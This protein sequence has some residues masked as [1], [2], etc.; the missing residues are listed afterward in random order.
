[1]NRFLLLLALALTATTLQAKQVKVDKAKSIALQFMQTSTMAKSNATNKSVGT[2]LNLVYTATVDDAIA[3][4]AAATTSNLFYVFNQADNGGFVI[5]AADDAVSPILAYS[6]E[7]SF[8]ADNIPCNVKA[9][10]DTYR[11]A[12][13][14]AIE[15]GVD[16]SA[17]WN[18]V[19]TRASE[20][21]EGSYL[22]TS[23]WGQGYPYNAKTPVIAE[24]HCVTG[25]VATAMA[26]IMYYWKYPKAGTGSHEY[27]WNGGG[28]MLSADFTEP[29]D[30]ANMRDTY[31]YN[32]AYTQDEVDAISHLLSQCGISVDMDYYDQSGA[33]TTTMRNSLC[34]YFGYSSAQACSYSLTN[35]GQTEWI[36]IIKEEIDNGRPI[37]YS[38]NGHAYICDGYNS[39]DYLHVNFGWSGGSDGFYQFMGTNAYLNRTY[40]NMECGLIPSDKS[41]Y[42]DD[43]VNTYS[44]KCS[45]DESTVASGT[46]LTFYVNLKHSETVSID[47]VTVVKVDGNNNILEDMGITNYTSISDQSYYASCSVSN[48]Y[49]DQED[50]AEYT[51][52]P[53]YKVDGKWIVATD[54]TPIVKNVKQMSSCS[55]TNM[56]ISFYSNRKTMLVGDVNRQYVIIKPSGDNF[57]GTI[58]VTVNNE[59][60][61]TVYKQTS[62]VVLLSG[63]WTPLPVDY[64]FMEAGT[65]TFNVVAYNSAG[66]KIKTAALELTVYEETYLTYFGYDTSKYDKVAELYPNAMVFSPNT[67]VHLKASFHNPTSQ[68]VTKTYAIS[69][70]AKYYNDVTASS[71][72]AEKTITIPANGDASAYIDVVV[73]SDDT[74]SYNYFVL[75]EKSDDSSYS[76]PSTDKTATST[77]KNYIRYTVGTPQMIFSKA[78]TVSGEDALTLHVN[79]EAWMTFYLQVQDA[80]LSQTAGY[81]LIARLYDGDKQVGEYKGTLDGISDYQFSWPIGGFNVSPGTYTLKFALDQMGTEYEI[82]DTSGSVAAYSVKIKNP[83]LLPEQTRILNGSEDYRFSKNN[84]TLQKGE[85]T[86]LKFALTN[87]HSTKFVGTIKVAE[88]SQVTPCLES[89]EKQ[90]TI[91]GNGSENVYGELSVTVPTNYRY[92]GITY[93][94]FAKSQY[95]DEYRAISNA[96]FYATISNASGIDNTT[97]GNGASYTDGVITTDGNIDDARVFDTAGRNV[98]GYTVKGNTLDLRTLPK[99]VYVVKIDTEN[100]APIKVKVVR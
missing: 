53:A 32:T 96:S 23:K 51:F 33:S 46:Q 79:T 9:V 56:Y 49:N 65:Y 86:K 35:V 30:W 57:K 25:C 13:T 29:F 31:D 24:E 55:A 61:K 7:N 10:L 83:D 92:S 66:T 6:H 75:A 97:I 80:G 72:L 99:G 27:Y 37:V 52:M 82:K 91:D 5:V 87:P 15:S 85:T 98:A 45:S 18:N 67:T 78:P 81:S 58:E 11:D 36:R 48:L 54:A 59:A 90:I 70:Q 68:S 2:E 60:G 43:Y 93:K 8:Q 20:S 21:T 19:A 94:L 22:V 95:D 63:S 34:N 64:R 76:S 71:V 4:R 38:S 39:S 28:K 47:A 77:P 16:A 40:Q 14:A 17:E 69:S 84:T 44:F 73:G 42:S 26:Q 100:G 50:N 74:S 41:P 88:T 1:M 12:I 3:T 89:E 62:N